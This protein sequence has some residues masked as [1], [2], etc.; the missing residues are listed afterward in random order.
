M[1]LLGQVKQL[2]GEVFHGITQSQVKGKNVSWLGEGVNFF[3]K[4]TKF[5]VQ[6]QYQGKF[7]PKT[8]CFSPLEILPHYFI[9]LYIRYLLIVLK[10]LFFD[11]IFK[12]WVQ[13]NQWTP[14]M[15]S[16]QYFKNLYKNFHS[17]HP[18]SYFVVL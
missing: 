1:P 18:C 7:C 10:L 2:L 13:Y 3:F 11:L 6:L 15:E 14:D 9:L 17:R 16:T 4:S 12:Q 5:T 8:D